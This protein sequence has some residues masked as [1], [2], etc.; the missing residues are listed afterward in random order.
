MKRSIV[1]GFIAGGFGLLSMG[2][3]GLALYYMSYPLHY[4]LFGDIETWEGKDLFWPSILW[5]GMLWGLAFPVAGWFDMRLARDARGAM[6]RRLV[7]L[8]ILWLGAGLV[9]IVVAL[10]SGYR[11]P[12]SGIF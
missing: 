3:L 4:P 6:M 2:A 8:A 1:A 10:G 12:S 5:A 9:W 7:Y 11:F